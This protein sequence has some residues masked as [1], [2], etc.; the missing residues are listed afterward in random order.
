MDE[1]VLCFW[2]SQRAKCLRHS[3]ITN[4]GDK[5]PIM[6][7]GWLSV[8]V[9][10]KRLQHWP[11]REKIVWIFQMYKSKKKI[12]RCIFNIT[13]RNEIKHEFVLVWEKWRLVSCK[14]RFLVISF[15]YQHVMKILSREI[16]LSKC[17]IFVFLVIALSV[18]QFST[19]VSM[20][21]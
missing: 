5:R 7:N 3:H 16:F 20:Y 8:C 11:K 4:W 19:T 18:I 21:G 17:S 10:G 9:Q 12:G 15:Q 14:V 1:G 2:F 13:N 6:R